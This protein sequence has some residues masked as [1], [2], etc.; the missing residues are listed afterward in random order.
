ME[1]AAL[2][3]GEVI[4]HPKGSWR[5]IAQSLLFRGSDGDVSAIKEAGDR[6]D[7]KVAQPIAGDDELP[8]ISIQQ[9]ER[10]IFDPKAEHPDSEGVSPAT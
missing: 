5:A 4:Q 10:V 6:V 2:A 9:I 8:P 1:A 3:N 7:G